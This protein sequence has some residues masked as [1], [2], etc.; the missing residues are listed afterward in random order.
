M[1]IPAGMDFIGYIKEKIQK[2][3]VV[4]LLLTPNYL[5]SQ[6][7][8]AELGASWA[9]THRI[10]PLLAPPLKYSDVKGVLAATQIETIKEGLTKTAITLADQLKLNLNFERWE[11]KKEKFLVRLPSILESLPKPKN[12]SSAEYESLKEAHHQATEALG[13]AEQEIENLKALNKDLLAC[14]DADQVAEVKRK[15][16]DSNQLEVNLQEFREALSKLPSVVT[17][18]IFRTHIGQRSNFDP[19]R[20]KECLIE[21]GR[22]VQEGRLILDDGFELNR[23]DPLVKKA[24]KQLKA[25]EKYLNSEDVTEEMVNAFE[26]EHEFQ[27]SLANRN[28]WQTFLCPSLRRYE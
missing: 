1:G 24:V 23:Q 16:A 28:L 8:I 4:L 18:V 3:E 5:A 11:A 21:A 20:E 2:P 17:Y 12:P 26:E 27:L 15:H 9:M 13:A 14:K 6:F 10:L 7:C 25:T 22:A 19:Y